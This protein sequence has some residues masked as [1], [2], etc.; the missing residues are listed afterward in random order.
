MTFISISASANDRLVE[1]DR[2]GQTKS[3]Q[4]HY[5]EKSEQ[6]NNPKD[7]PRRYT[8]EEYYEKVLP[9]STPSMSPGRVTSEQRELKN[10]LRPVFII[11]SDAM[12]ID[13]LKRNKAVLVENQA[14]GMLVEVNSID[15]LKKIGKIG[16]GLQIAPS[17]GEQIAKLLNIKHYPI[18]ITNQGIEQ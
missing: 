1:V 7:M 5:I 2:V 18:L 8:P 9:I 15:E 3:I 6:K 13:W 17:S 4:Y 16:V 10:I 14:L 12:S 11:G